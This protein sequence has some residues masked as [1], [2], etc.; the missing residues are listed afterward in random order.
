VEQA[1]RV[2]LEVAAALA[3]VV[4]GGVEAD[5]VPMESVEQ[6]LQPGL[7][8]GKVRDAVGRLVTVG[9]AQTWICIHI[10][11]ASICGSRGWAP[12]SEENL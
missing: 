3:A 9:V 1:G 6:L 8:A 4:S 11:L 7:H 5:S 2:G 10:D 12:T